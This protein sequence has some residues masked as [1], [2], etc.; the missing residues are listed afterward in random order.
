MIRSLSIISALILAGAAQAF[1]LW[2]DGK[3]VGPGP[4]A[5]ECTNFAGE[6]QG[7]CVVEKR[8]VRDNFTLEQEGCD[9]IRARGKDYYIGTVITVGAAIPA[10]GT[11]VASGKSVAVSYVWSADKKSLLL[12]GGIMKQPLT[13]TATSSTVS[14]KGEVKLDGNKLTL[15]AATHGEGGS[16]QVASCEYF[17]K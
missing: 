13:S 5:D 14:L 15:V 17:R 2:P 16:H 4:K 10:H 1:P 12:S 9:M 3:P 6:Y 7:S 8:T 11:E